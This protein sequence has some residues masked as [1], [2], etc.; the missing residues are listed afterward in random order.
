MKII[1]P[2]LKKREITHYMCLEIDLLTKL[3]SL[4]YE[5]DDIDLDHGI[6]LYKK[7]EELKPLLRKATNLLT[8]KNTE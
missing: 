4:L 3:N 5:L 7:I 1:I 8:K 6:E 2:K